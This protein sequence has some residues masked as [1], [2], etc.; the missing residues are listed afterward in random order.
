MCSIPQ[1]VAEERHVH[2]NGEHSVVV[3]EDVA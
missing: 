2:V 3:K 1:A